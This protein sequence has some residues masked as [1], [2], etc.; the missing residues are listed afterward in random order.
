[1]NGVVAM[2]EAV[3]AVVVRRSVAAAA[4]L[5]R[6]SVAAAVVLARRS[7]AAS[8]ESPLTLTTL[9][10]PMPWERAT[11]LKSASLASGA[12]GAAAESAMRLCQRS[13]EKTTRRLGAEKRVHL[14]IV[15][16]V[17][18]IILTSFSD[19]VIDFA[20]MLTV[21]LLREAEEEVVGELVEDEGE[22]AEEDAMLGY[23]ESDV[24]LEWRMMSRAS[25]R[26]VVGLRS[27]MEVAR[28]EER[29]SG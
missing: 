16:I 12:A 2:A 20:E 8:P 7:V 21:G 14:N 19:R 10:C 18:A 25:V 9:L 6:R 4:V 17:S 13:G 27:R 5:A 3:A 11:M 24:V 1:M 29:K 28:F 23:T 15:L 26:G 22:E